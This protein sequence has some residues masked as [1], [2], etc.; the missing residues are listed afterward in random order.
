M[1]IQYKKSTDYK[2]IFSTATVD[3]DVIYT[4]TVNGSYCKELEDVTLKVN[5]CSPLATSYSYAIAQSGNDYYYIKGVRFD[6]VEKK[7]E[8]RL[9]E[10]LVNHY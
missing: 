6:G 10:R 2:S 7:P 5:T 8:E 1:T 3:P 9:V 4:N